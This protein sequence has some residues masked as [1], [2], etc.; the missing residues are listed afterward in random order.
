MQDV[1]DRE[2]LGQRDGE[3]VFGTWYLQLHLSV[4]LKLLF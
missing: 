3:G 4:N 1:N 2:K